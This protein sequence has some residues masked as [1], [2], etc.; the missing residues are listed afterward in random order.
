MSTLNTS[1][2]KV[3]YSIRTDLS[4]DEY[5]ELFS[6]APSIEIAEL[7]FI[8]F[9]VEELMKICSEP[10]ENWDDLYNKITDYRYRF[11]GTNRKNEMER[12][13]FKE[14]LLSA[15]LWTLKIFYNFYTVRDYEKRIINEYNFRTRVKKSIRH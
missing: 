1:S 2:S 5:G 3:Y 13:E 10:L 12:V 14:A 4:D 15:K 8:N 9:V 11:G 7:R 6:S